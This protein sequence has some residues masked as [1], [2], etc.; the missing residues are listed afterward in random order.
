MRATDVRDALKTAIE[1]I[2]PDVKSHGGDVFKITEPGFDAIP[3]DRQCILERSRPQ[4]PANKLLV[5]ADPYSISFEL[6]VSYT[7][8]PGVASRM[9][10]DGD[11]I[12]DALLDVPVTNAQIL[13]IEIS[14]GADLVDEMGQRAASYTIDLEYDRRDT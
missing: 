1:A 9:L 4:E 12:L 7:N 11:K 10:K 13:T 6:I 14:G 3:M 5:S 8:T 2:T